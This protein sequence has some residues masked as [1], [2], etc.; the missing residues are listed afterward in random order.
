ML[1]FNIEVAVVQ[2]S[3]CGLLPCKS[4]RLCMFIYAEM[5][6][7]NISCSGAELLNFLP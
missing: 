1:Y 2:N 3:A 5:T 7:Y 6:Y 4:P